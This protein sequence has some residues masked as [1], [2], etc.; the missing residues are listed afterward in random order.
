MHD[1][2]IVVAGATGNLGSR[3]VI[4]LL[5]RGA[6]VKALVRRSTS[7]DK[8][9]RLQELGAPTTCSQSFCETLNEKIPPI[10]AIGRAIGPACLCYLFRIRNALSR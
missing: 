7:L 1:S 2:T 10:L 4:A 6:G 8:L 3:I 9:E 5:E